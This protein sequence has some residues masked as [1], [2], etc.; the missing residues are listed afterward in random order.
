MTKQNNLLHVDDD[1]DT[2]IG[3]V[4][5][6]ERTSILSDKDIQK[7]ERIRDRVRSKSTGSVDVPAHT[8]LTGIHYPQE[9]THLSHLQS[10]QRLIRSALRHGY[11]KDTKKKVAH[12]VN[13]L[14]EAFDL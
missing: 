4:D 8:R 9:Y 11:T 13:L 12:A 2:D 5:F 14:T 7:M 3:D 1:N 10:I 6:M